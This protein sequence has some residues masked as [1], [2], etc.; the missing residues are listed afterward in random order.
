M[1]RTFLLLPILLV[2]FSGFSQD[3]TG[4]QLLD[5]AIAFHDPN[6]NWI[7]FKGDFTVTMQTP[8]SSNRTSEIGL[9]FAKEA[10]SL[11][12][13][14]DQDRYTYSLQKD[15]CRIELNGSTTIAE[16]DKERL[17]LSCDRAAMYRDYYTYLYGLPMKLKD[18]GTVLDE[19]VEKRTF[20]GKEYL[21]LK[22]TYEAEVG[23]D[24]WYFYFDPKTYAMEV[25]QFYH[26]ESKNDGEYILLEDLETVNG[27]Q[28]PKTRKWYYNKDDKFLG[29]DILN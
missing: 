24:I 15:S 4:P 13:T 26:D 21:V 16:S 23:E 22:A 25:Y 6:G 3:P 8:K 27:I 2:T 11:Q 10:F 12:V 7:N 14:K 19:K 18:P 28:M 20:K 9:D 1:I 5:K 17:R 29:A